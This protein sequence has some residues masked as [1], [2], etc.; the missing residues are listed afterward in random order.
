MTENGSIPGH[1]KNALWLW[2][3]V[4][5]AASGTAA[6]LR[7]KVFQPQPIPVRVAEV[8][9]GTV[10]DTI[11]NTRAGSV[12]VRRRARISPQIGGKVVDLPAT[13]GLSVHRGD[14]LIRLDDSVARAELALARTG[15]R[16]AAAQSDEACLLSRQAARELERY[17]DLKSRGIASEQQ[18]DS[19]TT[20]KERAE[21]GCRAAV[22]A[23]EKAR[24][25]TRLAEKQLELTRMRAP[26]DGIIAEVSTELGEW[27][28]P[29]PPGLPMPPVIDL[30]DPASIYISAP[31]DEMDAERVHRGQHVRISVDSR[32]GKSFP[33]RVV[34]VAPFVEDS[35]EQNRTIEVEAE[36]ENPEDTRSLIC[37]LSADL[38]IILDSRTD[39]LRIP[40]LAIAD[41]N[42]VL[43][44]SEGFLEARKIET[45]LNNWRWTEIRRGLAEGELVVTT[46]DSEKIVPGT[47]AR[48]D[49]GTD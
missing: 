18:L 38:E 24:A 40:S 36:F 1:R 2:L 8:E 32:Q 42:E 29:S 14:L 47:P 45:G 11:A 7:Y 16:T 33:G 27:V 35:L 48:I 12:K 49:H 39:V 10:E 21:A 3:L 46:R 43:V 20:E 25:A 4:L 17:I 44:L 28:T 22:A 31:I 6:L 23:L 26:F 34:R 15:E 5:I 9:K 13:R 41:S 19:L 37:G 30:I